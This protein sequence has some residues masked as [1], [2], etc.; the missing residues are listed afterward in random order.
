[1]LRIIGAHFRKLGR[2]FK[3][4][5]DEIA[6]GIE[7][8]DQALKQHGFQ[9]LRWLLIPRLVLWA[10]PGVYY[11]VKDAALLEGYIELVAILYIIAA[12]LAAAT[13]ITAD[14]P[15]PSPVPVKEP[16]A[17]VQTR[18]EKRR[19]IMRQA[20]FVLFGE[21]VKYLPGLT[22]PISLQSV[23]ANPPY[24]INPNRTIIHNMKVMKGHCDADVDTI[25]RLLETIIGDHIQAK[26][27]P[28]AVIDEYTS[29][30]GD[31]VP[32][33]VVDGV[34][35][36]GDYYR[37]G[38]AITDDAEAAVYV[39]RHTPKVSGVDMTNQAV[40]DEDFD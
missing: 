30:N 31:K 28:V 21:L 18:A 39:E 35:D 32:G 24:I 40:T 29:S 23:E 33:L 5:F 4:C 6:T 1:M 9:E 2:S 10:I 3:Q 7:T 27:L 13:P 17:A 36:M 22:P 12:I 14:T 15:T 11:A 25:L 20:A 16:I 38:L 34:Y 8:N 26:D 19:E 37:V